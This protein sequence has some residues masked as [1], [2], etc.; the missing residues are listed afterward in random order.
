MY[1]T[2]GSTLCFLKGLE[3][4]KRVPLL[5]PFVLVI[6]VNYWKI[7]VPVEGINKLLSPSDPFKDRL[8][9][10]I[11]CEH[12]QFRFQSEGV[13]ERRQ[14]LISHGLWN[15]G[16]KPVPRLII[17]CKTFNQLHC[18]LFTVISVIP[19]CLSLDYFKEHHSDKVIMSVEQQI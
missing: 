4:I 15:L 1:V 5:F 17:R 7:A 11:L 14:T 9:N 12:C 2:K 16:W 8:A 3:N 19:F 10:K 13:T 6:L 18:L